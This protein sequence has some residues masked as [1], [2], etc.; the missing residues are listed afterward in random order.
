MRLKLY[1]CAVLYRELCAA[2]A[3]SRNRVDV[4][5]LP[6]G[7]HNLGSARMLARL[8][9][10]VDREENAGYDAIILGY[11]LC[12]LGLVGLTAGKIP[13]VIP[14]AHDCITF[15]LGSKEK[16]LDYFYSHPGVY[17]KTSGWIER[18]DGNGSES[19]PQ[20]AGCCSTDTGCS[21]TYSLE[22]LVGKYGEEDGREIFDI[23]TGAATKYTQFTYIE[24]GV[25]PS[26]VFEKIVKDEARA[27]GWKYEKI[28]GDMAL[29]NQLV[30]GDWPEGN[31]LTLKPGFRVEPSYDLSI[32]KAVPA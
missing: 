4:E 1:A 32:I 2:A 9:E 23:M 10:T 18:T 12:G 29:M 11:G 7:L 16:Y 6:Q 17:F 28:R 30:D 25:E 3:K 14:R 13:L 20:S 26:E 5:F 31:F 19:N 24:M 21:K 15:Y 22:E 27:K 8:Q